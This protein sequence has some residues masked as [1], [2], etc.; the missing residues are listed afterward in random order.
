MV[1]DTRPL[2]ENPVRIPLGQLA[3]RTGELRR[4]KLLVVHC[5]G[6]Y[7][8]STANFTGGFDAWKSAGLPGEARP[9]VAPDQ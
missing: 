8:S 5:Q 1:L 2:L 4:D 3:A 9:S 7:R 6:G